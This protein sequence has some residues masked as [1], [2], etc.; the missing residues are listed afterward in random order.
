MSDERHPGGPTDPARGADRDPDPDG[1]DHLIDD[2][3]AAASDGRGAAGGGDLTAALRRVHALADEPVP[4]QVRSRH[5]ARIRGDAS[6]GAAHGRAARG[7]AA[8]GWFGVLQRRLAPIAAVAVALLVFAGGGTVALA[9][10]ADPDDA[11]YGL[12]RASEQAWIALPRGS[13]RAAEVHLAIA[14]RRIGEAQRAPHHA[15]G[16]VAASVASIEAAAEENPEEAIT[17]FVR[18]LGDG[19]GALPANASPAARAA[20]ARNCHRIAQHHGL[21]DLAVNCPDAGDFEHPGRGRG[22]GPADGPRGWGPGGRPE[23]EVGP[24][25]GVPAHERGS[26]GE[27]E[28]G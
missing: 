20:L 5:L 9:Q 21:E 1:V 8:R 14:E 26:P 12:K 18:L 28:D 25:P 24:P 15:E 23:G 4:P 27:D 19:E 22:A 3:L 6:L 17:T 16:L 7:R 13:E 10:D 2:L 11:L